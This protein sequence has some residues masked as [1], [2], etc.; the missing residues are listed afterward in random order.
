MANF[1][2][3]SVKLVGHFFFSV[4]HTIEFLIFTTNDFAVYEGDVASVGKKNGDFLCHKLDTFARGKSV[5]LTNLSRKLVPSVWFLKDQRVR[6]ETGKRPATL[7]KFSIGAS[8]RAET[9]NALGT[10]PVE[11]TQRDDR[12]ELCLRYISNI[13][14]IYDFQIYDFEIYEAHIVILIYRNN[15]SL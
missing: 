15:L 10:Y 5:I 14:E 2:Q 1:M 12:K 11:K 6:R 13:I 9:F 4:K 3:F 8:S 7:S